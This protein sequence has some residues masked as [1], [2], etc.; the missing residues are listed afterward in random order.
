[1]IKRELENKTSKKLAKKILITLICLL[2][3]NAFTDDAYSLS[4]DFKISIAGGNLVVPKNRSVQRRLYGNDTSYSGILLLRIAWVTENPPEQL[5]QT[6]TP[7]FRKLEFQL[8]KGATTIKTMDCFSHLSPSK[9]T[10]KCVYSIPV[11]KSIAQAAGN[12]SLK[13]SNKSDRAAAMFVMAGSVFKVNCPAATSIGIS[14]GKFS[15]PYGGQTRVKKLLLSGNS[16]G[17]KHGRIRLRAKWHVD[18]VIPTFNKLKIEL[19]KPNGQVAK[20]GNYYSYHVKDRSPIFDITYDVSKNDGML[21]GDWKLRVTNYSGFNV[22][23]FNI[24]KGSSEISPLVP[25]F[26]STFKAF[27]IP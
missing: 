27:C 22:V 16:T 26:T 7:Q 24:E 2:T 3:I 21:Q 12:W 6:K 10:P 23:G 17:I 13:I 1:M 14:G 8:K 19:L 18:R 15:I 20:T 5:L 9:F 25:H 4:S 11:S